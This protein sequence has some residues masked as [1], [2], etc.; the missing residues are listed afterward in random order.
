MKNKVQPPSC[1]TVTKVGCF[2]P[3]W[4]PQLHTFPHH[5]RISLAKHSPMTLTNVLENLSIVGMQSRQWGST[6]SN[7][8]EEVGK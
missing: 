5:W 8:A 3:F 2:E 7:D 4:L 6:V 1:A